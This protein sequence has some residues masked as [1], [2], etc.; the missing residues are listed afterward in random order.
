MQKRNEPVIIYIFSVV[1][2]IHTAWDSLCD[3]SLIGD[4]SFVVSGKKKGGWKLLRYKTGDLSEQPV[5]IMLRDK[6]DRITEVWARGQH[7]LAVSYG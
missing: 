2:E 7:C 4:D 3:V 1:Q 5:S 6:P